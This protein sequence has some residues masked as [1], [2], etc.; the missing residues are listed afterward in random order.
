M[1]QSR[2]TPGSLNDA[3]NGHFGKLLYF[4]VNEQLDH[5]Q[6]HLPILINRTVRP[7]KI[8][9]QWSKVVIPLGP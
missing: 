8:L 1:V 6:N 7:Q 4:R 9:Y 2:Y 3:I 5:N